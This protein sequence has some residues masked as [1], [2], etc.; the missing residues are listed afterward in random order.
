MLTFK[1]R[2]KIW[3]CEQGACEKRNKAVKHC[4]S[5]DKLIY[6]KKTNYQKIVI[7]DN[8]FYGRVLVLDGIF[9]LSEKD[10]FVH[11][12]MITH[13]FLFSH[14]NPERV[15]IIGGGDGGALREVLRHPVK[16]VYLVDIDKKMIEISQKYLPFVSKGAFKDKRVKVF[17]ENGSEFIKNKR[18]QNFFDVVIIDSNDPIGPS[19]A[20]FS[21][22]FYKDVFQI[23]KK[24]N[25]IMVTLV[26]LFLDSKDLIKKIV[27]KIG[28][29]FSKIQ[30]YRAAVPVYY[31][32][33]FCYIGASKKIALKKNDFKKIKIRFKVLQ[34]KGKFKY[35][36]PEIHFASM[37]LPKY[38]DSHVNI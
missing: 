1:K 31:C 13:P 6:T 23:L 14:P 5:I 27:N 26:G 9:Q 28:S 38:L 17:F 35:Y 3:F 33:D 37:I 2:K 22:E 21:K 32:G 29:V 19:L 16:E 34:K 10:E 8:S 12:E 25:G 4:L 30:L 36:S 24:D 11:H 7:F 15:L 20:L 18:L